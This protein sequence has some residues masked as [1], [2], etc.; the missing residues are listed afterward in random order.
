MMN[1]FV[2]YEGFFSLIP[3]IFF[4][5]F[6][7]V[8]IIFG[9]FANRLQYLNKRF[10]GCRGVYFLSLVGLVILFLLL[11]YVSKFDNDVS[12]Y[13]FINIMKLLSVFFTLIIFIFGF[14]SW[15]YDNKIRYE[16]FII[17]LFALWGSLWLLSA[18]NFLSLYVALE[19]Q[20]L[21]LYVLAA[22][23]SNSKSIEAGIK[24]FIMG[25]VA[26]GF[27][28]FGILCCYGV[29]GIINFFDYSIFFSI[30]YSSL[31]DLLYI[32]I[33]GLFCILSA[34]FFKF[35]VAPF[36][37]WVP[38]V[39]EG[40]PLLSVS[41]F[42]IVAK[43]PIYLI[44]IRLLYISFFE[45]FEFWHFLLV[46]VG[47]VS[48]VIGTI[49][50]LGQLNLRRLLA[51][52]GIGHSGFIMLSLSTGVFEGIHASFIYL[53][54][55]FLNIL[56]FLGIMLV[57]R[58]SQGF[59]GL[60]TLEDLKLLYTTKPWLGVFLIL[61]IFSI[62]GIPPLAGFFSKFFVLKALFSVDMYFFGI[63]CIVMSVIASVYYLRVIKFLL[64]ESEEA[65]TYYKPVNYI[66]FFILM[67]GSLLNIGFYFILDYLFAITRVIILSIWF[68]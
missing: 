13:F 10:T 54:V 31:G 27:L 38:D 58:D 19:L 49:G 23:G 1:N 3:E 34:L 43:I 67:L 56:I 35:A 21:C 65:W 57:V 60:E 53:L 50:A 36:H 66:G 26:S 40:S 14:K 39:Y 46:F 29:T 30:G 42:A 9:I 16:Y 51:Y 12:S 61:N 59:L 22:S 32:F 17:M 68:F 20:G 64:F 15:V 18:A 48:L 6:L 8:L 47:V 4:G 2:I 55:Y 28:L 45:L 41:F 7:S 25:S 5:I 37:N 11:I 44:F 63:L 52:S 24:Y 33:F 62:S